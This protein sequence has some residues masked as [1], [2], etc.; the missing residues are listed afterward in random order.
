MHSRLVAYSQKAYSHYDLKKKKLIL[1]FSKD[2]YTS[3]FITKDLYF[4]KKLILKPE[5]KN[6]SKKYELFSSLIIIR[7]VS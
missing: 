3:R 4:L 2:H 7:N 1:L 6:A 5:K